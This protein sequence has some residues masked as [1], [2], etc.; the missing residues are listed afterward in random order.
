[1]NASGLRHLIC[2]TDRS[3]TACGLAIVRRSPSQATPWSTARDTDI[4]VWEDDARPTDDNY[5]ECD[6]CWTG[7][8]AE[9]GRGT[10][11]A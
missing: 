1:M 2:E 4:A 3:Q 11:A 6:Q 5:D 9:E 7:T 8:D 10:D